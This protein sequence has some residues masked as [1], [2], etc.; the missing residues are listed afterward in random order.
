M[1]TKVEQ[2]LQGILDGVESGPDKVTI[3]QKCYTNGTTTRTKLD[4]GLCGDSRCE[5]CNKWAD[6]LYE[7]Y[8]EKFK[9]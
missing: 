3:V 2:I 7:K 6:M 5:N 4:P 8:K 1:S 9:K